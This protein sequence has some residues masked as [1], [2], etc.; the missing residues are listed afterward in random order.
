M[1]ASP[2]PVRLFNRLQL[3][4]EVV[5][6]CMALC[7]GIATGAGVLL[8]RSAIEWARSFYWHDL[9]LWLMGWHRGAVVLVPALGGL[10][11]SLFYLRLRPAEG[12]V[13]QVSDAVARQDGRLPYAQIPLRTAAA[14]LSLGAGA[15]LGPE[16]P[17]VELGSNLGSLLGQV[18]RFSGDR[19]R[20]LVVAGA[21]AGLSAGFNAPIAGMFFAIHL[22]LDDPAIGATTTLNANL[23]AVAI[24][25]VLSELVV[26]VGLDGNPAFNL[27]AYEVRSLW[28]LPLYIGLGILASG[29]AIAYSLAIDTARLF[30]AGRLPGSAPWAKLPA[31]IKLFLGGAIL[32]SVALWLPEAIGIGYETVESILQDAPFAVGLLL[33][34]L[35]VKLAMTTISMACGFIGGIFAPA[36]CLGAILGSAYGQ[37]LHSVLPSFVPIAEPPAYALV[38]MA[39]VLAG[40]IRAPLTAVLLLFEMTRDYRIVLPLMAAVG[41]CA[42]LVDLANKWRVTSRVRTSGSLEGSDI[43]STMK[44]AEVMSL[45]PLLLRG[46]MPLSLAARILTAGTAQSALVVDE[47]QSLVG[48]ITPL[49]LKR[50]LTTPH[51]GLG[52]Q[53]LTAADICTR[54]V[55][56]AYADESLAEAL[57]RMSFRDVNQLP[58]VDRA[59]P[60]RVLGLVERQAIVN[61]VSATLTKQAIADKIASNHQEVAGAISTDVFPNASANAPISDPEFAEKRP[62]EAATDKGTVGSLP[63]S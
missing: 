32:G 47:A 9:A 57:K 8:F 48:I 5:V 55:Q 11:V 15:S 12:G 56:R 36:I 22:L 33:V 26:Q 3:P 45:H 54:D 52:W 2:D 43:L 50:A 44:I 42:W 29:I 4:G 18:F 53:Y 59:S 30:L 20:L 31:A 58:I 40:S 6:L 61:A 1:T 25:A 34:L 62:T 19:T 28:E 41:F 17:S 51:A 38:G 60:D 35:V 27:P 14:A 21:A 16:G 10:V 46:T 39:A 49:D 13:V 23:S 37:V 63:N 7:V 24:A